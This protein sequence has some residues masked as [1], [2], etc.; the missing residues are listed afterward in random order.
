VGEVRKAQPAP[1]LLRHHR[2]ESVV[3]LSERSESVVIL[4]ERSESKDLLA[5]NRSPFTVHRSPRYKV[6]A[7]PAAYFLDQ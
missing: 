5:V 7:H 3:I 6:G 2:R 4:S 1:E